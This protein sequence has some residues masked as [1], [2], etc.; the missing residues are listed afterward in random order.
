MLAAA[1]KCFEFIAFGLAEFDAI[2]YPSS[3]PPLN[4][5]TGWPGESFCKNLHAQ[6]AGVYPPVRPPASPA[7]SGSRHPVIFLRRRAFSL[8]DVL[9]LERAGFVRRQPGVARSIEVLIDPKL[10]PE[11]MRSRIQHV[12]ITVTRYWSNVFLQA[13]PAICGNICRSVTGGKIRHEPG[14][15]AR[16]RVRRCATAA[17]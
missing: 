4:N 5:S 8:P 17:T 9:T 12:R 2:G 11:L 16:N 13:L 7:A 10:L 14:F 6:A 3:M 15:T 1:E